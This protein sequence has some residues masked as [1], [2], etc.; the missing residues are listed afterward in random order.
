MHARSPL[1]QEKLAQLP[2]NAGVYLM[3]DSEG[4]IIYV[5][6]AAC[7]KNRVRSYF[8]DPARLDPKTA[9][10]V[11][12]IADFETIIVDNPNEAL[13]L[14][15]NLIKQYDPHY[16]I[17]LRDDKHYPYLKLTMTE[18]FPRLVIA[19]RAKNDGNRYFGPYVNSGAMHQAQKLIKKMFPLRSCTAKSWPANH[20]ACLNAHIGLCKAPC[21]GKISQEEYGKIVQQVS[22]FLEGKTKTLSREI[23]AE[24]EKASA[25]LRFEDAA[26]LRDLAQTV[27]EMYQR[28]QLDQSSR[29][30][31]YDILATAIGG[32]QCV[33]QVFFVRGGKVIG[34]D[35]FFILNTE[36]GDEPQ[37]LKS[38]LVEYYGGANAMPPYLL[39]PVLPEDAAELAALFSERAGHKV[40]FQV[41]QRGDKR[42][43]LNLVVNNAQLVLDQ[44]LN[45]RERKEEEAAAGLEG[46]RLALHLP[47]LPKRMECYDI[48]HIQG[49]SMVGSMVVFEGGHPAPKLYRHFRIKEVEG[50][51]D[52]ASLQEVLRR[53][54]QRGLEERATGKNPLDFG[55]FPDLLIIDGGKGQLS[56]VC[57]TLAQMGVTP[58]AII[59]LAKAEE[60][61]F[62]PGQSESLRLDRNDP[63]LK[64]LQRIRDEAHRFAIQHHRKLRAKAQTHSVLE[65]IPGVGPANRRRLLAA[66]GSV[67]AIKSASLEELAA[68][69]GISTKT[70][71]QI[72]QHFHQ[73]EEGNVNDD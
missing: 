3:K 13:I 18:A 62:L 72:Y 69:K 65:D 7:L 22:D 51:N 44:Y 49:T 32:G 50:N 38:F 56:A 1:L 40:R 30:E 46:L 67:K 45:S 10:L 59:S 39:F 12:H 36:P 52:F 15:S 28:Q 23:K 4:Q 58:K 60:E 42:R 8:Q 35:H 53:R 26:R 25:E 5:G 41:P 29:E 64:L 68:V 66:F 27:E 57:A 71:A 47:N 24:M 19:R 9:A 61:I 54:F 16:N 34:R 2:N 33:L 55:V 70:A 48:S 63:A 31:N 21:M 20:R 11:E 43:L 37:V 14:E 6:K 17:R 73:A